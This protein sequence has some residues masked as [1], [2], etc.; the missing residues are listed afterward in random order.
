MGIATQSYICQTHPENPQT[1][2]YRPHR[3]Q[4]SLFFPVGGKSRDYPRPP[5]S[6]MPQPPPILTVPPHSPQVRPLFRA[7]GPHGGLRDIQLRTNMEGHRLGPGCFADFWQYK[8]YF[9]PTKLLGGKLYSGAKVL[10][11]D[12]NKATQ[13]SP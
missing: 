7:R 11:S 6:R 5:G 3:R 9:I 12:T 8:L 10:I 4:L 2:I 13:K 1:P